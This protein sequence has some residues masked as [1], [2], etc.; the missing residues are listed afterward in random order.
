MFL[1]WFLFVFTRRGAPP[2]RDPSFP[3][4][5]LHTVSTLEVQAVGPIRPSFK[6]VRHNYVVCT[7][8]C[9]RI[10]TRMYVLD[11]AERAGSCERK[12]YCYW[13]CTT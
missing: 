13:A 6:T 8:Y 11:S 5:D 1:S 7:D 9:T 12:P 10:M 2:S 4:P 3:R